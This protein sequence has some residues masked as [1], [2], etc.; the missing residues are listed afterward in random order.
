M[1]LSGPLV[2]QV[3]VLPLLY[4][5]KSQA[6]NRRLPHGQVAKTPLN[7]NTLFPLA[8]TEDRY[9]PTMPTKGELAAFFGYAKTQSL[10]THIL[11]PARVNQAGLSMR[12]IRSNRCRR[13]PR[14]LALII[15]REESITSLR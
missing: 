14:P 5:A 1:P 3:Q 13:I 8:P 4:K 15:Y 7:M 11:T 10:Y 6:E 12:L 2:E 9:L